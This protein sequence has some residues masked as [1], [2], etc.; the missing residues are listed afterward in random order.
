[1]L[2][3]TFSEDVLQL[4]SLSNQNACQSPID[5][6]PSFR[7]T[8]LSLTFPLVKNRPIQLGAFQQRVA[9]PPEAEC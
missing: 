1:M 7:H 3:G 2:P 6:R 5:I 8:N 9:G 4:K